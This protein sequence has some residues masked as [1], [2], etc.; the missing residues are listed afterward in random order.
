MGV[1]LSALAEP[2]RTYHEP[3]GSS[4]QRRLWLQERSDRIFVF[5]QVN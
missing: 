5:A 2:N 4:H 1:G 3:L